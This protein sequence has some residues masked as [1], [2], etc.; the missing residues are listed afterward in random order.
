MI[1][2]SRRTFSMECSN[3][4]SV[5]DKKKNLWDAAMASCEL[6]EH[7][8]LFIKEQLNRILDSFSALSANKHLQDQYEFKIKK[9][10]TDHQQ[11]LHEKRVM[12]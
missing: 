5:L 9:V 1:D 4:H 6:R 8:Y 3:L 11:I 7:E 2:Q 12:D 10:E